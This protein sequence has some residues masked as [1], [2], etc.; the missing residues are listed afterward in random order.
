MI[1]PLLA[2]EEPPT[3][4]PGQSRFSD[5]TGKDRIITRIIFEESLAKR[6]MAEQQVHSIR[7][8]RSDA[9]KPMKILIN[10]VKA[11]EAES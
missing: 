7:P 5:R 6:S 4:S 8:L 10:R 11:E 1:R 9:S 2:V 3:P